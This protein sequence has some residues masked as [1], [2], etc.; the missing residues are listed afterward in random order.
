VPQ[1]LL[2]DWICVACYAK[3][4]TKIISLVITNKL[5]S[6]L[7]ANLVI[8]ARILMLAKPEQELSGPVK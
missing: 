3:Y 8:A 5:K 1:D 2:D 6:M 7:S 4:I